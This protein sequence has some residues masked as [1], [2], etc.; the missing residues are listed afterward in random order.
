MLF[1][2]LDLVLHNIVNC[3]VFLPSKMQINP[4]GHVRDVIKTVFMLFKPRIEMCPIFVA[5]IC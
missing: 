2:F 5:L 3:F 4:S 1:F